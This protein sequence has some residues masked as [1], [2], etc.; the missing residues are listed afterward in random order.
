MK[1]KPTGI[2]DKFP[3]V[4]HVDHNEVPRLGVPRRHIDV[5]KV[6]NNKVS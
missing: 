4:E 2:L 3:Q 1:M 5:G 6:Q